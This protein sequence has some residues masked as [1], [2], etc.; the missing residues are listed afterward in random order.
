MK[1]KLGCFVI[2]CVLGIA[3]HLSSAAAADTLDD[4]VVQHI[5]TGEQL[6]CERDVGGEYFF[7]ARVGDKVRLGSRLDMTGYN[8]RHE[9]IAAWMFYNEKKESLATKVLPIPIRE[10]YV[11]S[12]DRIFAENIEYQTL[13]LRN[14]RTMAVTIKI[15]KCPTSECNLQVTASKEEKQ[16]TIPLCEV[17]LNK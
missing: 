11:H 3:G 8:E 5:G 12:G 14:A 1:L 9:F 16:Y 17:F 2:G 10:K 7:L 15:K 6:L 13:N 4:W